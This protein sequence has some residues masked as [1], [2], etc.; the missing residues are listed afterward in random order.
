LTH[1]KD[2]EEKPLGRR[3]RISFCIKASFFPSFFD[4]FDFEVHFLQNIVT[5]RV[6]Q[7]AKKAH[8]DALLCL[9]RVSGFTLQTA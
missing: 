9:P 5:L 3:S 7:G 6:F 1:N 2:E 4:L 8:A